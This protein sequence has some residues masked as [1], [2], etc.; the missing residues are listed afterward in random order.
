M[1]REGAAGSPAG[2]RPPASRTAE[3]LGPGGSPL[4]TRRDRGRA[5][6]TPS[7]G[8]AGAPQQFPGAT[9][10]PSPSVRTVSAR[11]CGSGAS[12]RV[13]ASAPAPGGGARQPLRGPGHGR[14]AP[15]TPAPAAGAPPLAA[16]PPSLP[17]SRRC[18]SV[19]PSAG[20]Q[21]PSPALLTRIPAAL[22]VAAGIRSPAPWRR[23]R[24]ASAAAPRAPSPRR[25]PGAT[26]PWPLPQAR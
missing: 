8:P 20:S 3:E 21:P 12:G 16:P 4:G 17:P 9:G 25:G 7:L 18:P 26:R 5:S 15:C 1:P 14:A 2:A 6:V 23:Q 19:R 22:I 13:P 11:G 10:P 24:A